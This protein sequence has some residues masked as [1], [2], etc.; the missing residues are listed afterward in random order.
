M[1]KSVHIQHYKS[2]ADVHIK[3]NPITLLV[4]QNGSGKSNIIDALRFVKDAVTYGL[5]HA[6]SD[7][8]GIEVLRQYAPTRP[9][10][11][12]FNLEFSITGAGGIEKPASYSFRLSSSY[13][14]YKIETEEA[15]WYS[16]RRS[17]GDEDDDEDDE[18]EESLEYEMHR[19]VRSSAGVVAL[20]G[21]FRENTVP[22]DVLAL[23]ATSVMSAW[24]LV[25]ALQFM[26]FAQI[27]PNVLR[28]P[29]RPDT[30]RRLKENCSNWASV[31]K[32]M[33]QKRAPERRML[34]VME[35]MRQI[36]PGLK[37][38]TVKSVGGYLVPQF[39]VQDSPNAKAHYF[40]PIQLSDGTLRLFAILLTLYQLSPTSLLAMEEPEQTVHPGVLE[41]LV[42]A[43]RDVSH[44]AQLI[45][46]THSPYLL[47]HF[48][49][50]EIRVVKM[51]KGETTVKMMRKGQI[52]TVKQGLM[53]IS[54]L[55]A[56]DGLDIEP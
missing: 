9:Y 14:E 42:E 24:P 48:D 38:V 18:D 40:D 10:N 23:S 50:N 6:I 33:R 56:L 20:D 27:Y 26:R 32:A 21:A 25:R 49:T 22:S 34:Q 16:V 5:D 51:I 1:L 37:T 53:S 30:E 3:I 19:M 36:M 44:G 12:F 39:L 45:I 29:S 41:L 4:G 52:E 11:I 47:D 15:M 28:E 35:A 8:G 7:R 55:M 31:I 46:T 2:L 54:E 17:I 13:G 43:F